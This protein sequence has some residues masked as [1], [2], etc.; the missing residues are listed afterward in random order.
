MQVRLR[1]LRPVHCSRK[2]G[3]DAVRQYGENEAM[4]HHAGL[5]RVL[6]DVEARVPRVLVN[7]SPKI[8]GTL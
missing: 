8:D 1:P 6:T 5:T 7:H 4:P 2:S 3:S